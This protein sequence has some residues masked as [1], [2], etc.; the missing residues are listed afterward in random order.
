VERA[1]TQRFLLIDILRGFAALAVLVWHYQHFYLTSLTLPTTLVSRK[2][3]PFYVFLMPFYEYGLWAVDLFWVIS[4]FVFFAVYHVENHTI[5]GFRFFVRR[6]SR[7]Y[8]LHFATLI[9]VGLLQIWSEALF[10]ETQIYGNNNLYHFVLN[11]FL[12]SN[13]GFEKGFSFNAPIWSVSIEEVVYVGFFLY[14][15]FLRLNLR[16]TILMFVFS[17]AGF[18]V[19][20]HQIFFC[21]MVF[22]VGGIIFLAWRMLQKYPQW[23]SVTLGLA[24]FASS[25]LLCSFVFRFSA[26]SLRLLLA[27]GFPS[28]VFLCAALEGVI[29]KNILSRFVWIGDITYSTYLLHIPVQIAVLIFLKLNNISLNIANSGYFFMSFFAAVVIL[30]IMSYHWVERPAQSFLRKKLT[31]KFCATEIK[32]ADEILLKTE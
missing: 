12:A 28:L 22:F 24:G 13:W 26:P 29:P 9:L 7:L 1:T 5:D 10:G 16:N 30:S 20:R 19:T 3:Q 6:F 31:G 18:A 17:S 25:V 27:T 4:G 32:P 23:V 14:C 21:G 8:P 15:R 11:I 2:I